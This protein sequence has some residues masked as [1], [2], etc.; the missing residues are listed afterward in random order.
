M[1][2]VNSQNEQL[3]DSNKE[4][5]THKNF[6]PMQNSMGNLSKFSKEEPSINKSN[7]KVKSKNEENLSHREYDKWNS[8][9]M[10]DIKETEEDLNENKKSNENMST[11]DFFCLRHPLKKVIN[12]YR[13]F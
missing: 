4:N 8:I 2:L 6:S 1:N 12:L 11:K 5:S 10:K 9:Q 3:N 7:L 13:L